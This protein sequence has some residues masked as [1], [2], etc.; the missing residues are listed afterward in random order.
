MQLDPPLDPNEPAVTILRE[1]YRQI[2]KNP[3]IISLLP[4]VRFVRWMLAQADA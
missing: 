2:G 3:D 4:M 1:Y